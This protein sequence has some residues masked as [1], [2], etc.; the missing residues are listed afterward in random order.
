M[1]ASEVMPAHISMSSFPTKCRSANWE[2]GALVWVAGLNTPRVT[3]NES[4]YSISKGSAPSASTAVIY[5]FPMKQVRF[6]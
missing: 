4:V 6:P 5:I 2:R 3:E 1:N